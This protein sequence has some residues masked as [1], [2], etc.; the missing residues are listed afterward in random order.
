[1]RPNIFLHNYIKSSVEI[2]RFYAQTATSANTQQSQKEREREKRKNAGC[3]SHPI[4]RYKSAMFFS[5]LIRKSILLLAFSSQFWFASV[6]IAQANALDILDTHF[7]SVNQIRQ[8][9]YA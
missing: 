6:S 9:Q 3:R 4:V 2:E 7:T 5:V 1:M 8:H